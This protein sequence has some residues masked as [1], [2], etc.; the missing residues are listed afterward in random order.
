MIIPVLLEPNYHRSIWARQT[1]EG[2]EREAARKK[3]EVRMLGGDDYTRLDLPALLGEDER[4]IVILG[5]SI[6]WVPAAL[7][8]FSD[9]GIASLLISFNPAE[10]AAARGIVRMDYTAAMHTLLSYLTDC[11]HERAAL[12]G[13]NPNSSADMIKR[14]YF[15]QWNERY[16]HADAPN[17]FMNLASLPKCYEEFKGHARR[18]DAVICAN[19]IVAASLLT[20]LAADGI[21][22]P[23]D[24]YLLSFG[25]SALARGVKPSLTSVSLE[26]EE[27]GRRAVNLYAFLYRQEAATSVSMRIRGRM[28]VREST[29][30]APL[31]R[32]EG[33]PSLT[34]SRGGD[35]NFYSDPEADRLMR[36]EALLNSCTET[37]RAFLSELAAGK[38]F[39][40][41]EERLFLSVSAL[42]YRLKRI[43]AAAGCE[44]RAEFNDFLGLC[45]TLGLF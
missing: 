17:E 26:H 42:R 24:I 36:V 21:R 45:K 30:F 18:F 34:L 41:M 8:Y 7:N 38:S 25:D 6:S 20:R 32:P 16:P 37:D 9:R 22:V 13:F 33:A 2:I 3:Y 4:M 35:V 40:G 10:S 44:T 12:Y 19:D 5:T 11:G 28:T 29:A 39:E 43:M 31:R 27:L 15:A 14:D 23:E 1:L